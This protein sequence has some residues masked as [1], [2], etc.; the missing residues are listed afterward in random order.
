MAGAGGNGGGGGMAG[1]SGSAPLLGGDA[2]PLPWSEVDSLADVGS[3]P[4]VLANDKGGLHVVAH[5]QH[6]KLLSYS[7]EGWKAGVEYAPSVGSPQ[8]AGA[9]AA[10]LLAW[11]TSVEL[12][13]AAF[14]GQAFGT[15]T[16]LVGPTTID[17]GDLEL[18]ATSTG[19]SAIAFLSDDNSV[20]AA[21]WKNGTWGDFVIIGTAPNDGIARTAQ[22]AMDDM[23][24]AVVIWE[25]QDGVNGFND[26]EAAG[27]LFDGSTWKPAEVIGDDGMETVRLLD[28]A[29][30]R[31]GKGYGAWGETHLYLRP[32]DLATG[33]G[34]M[35]TLDDDPDWLKDQ[36]ALAVN[37]TGDAVVLWSRQKRFDF[38]P[39]VVASFRPAGGSWSTPLLLQDPGYIYE[40]P[41]A[42]LDN[43]GNA[44]LTWVAT[45]PSVYVVTY[46]KASG[47]SRTSR[48]FTATAPDT[49]TNAQVAI[50][51]GNAYVV[52]ATRN[53][54]GKQQLFATHAPL[55]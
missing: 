33:F 29:V 55:P 23:G 36:P 4:D 27:A 46:T 40:Y 28:M 10:P 20:W 17:S 54:T 24:R 15:T 9:A 7:T 47:W 41:A 45:G 1:M 49:V 2:A 25:Q 30:N 19:G 18:L 8:I 21:S 3:Y 51:G 14:N 53:S 48:L 42:C 13:S 35:T 12:Q 22:G 44:A 52:W 31:A 38:V 32:V 6:A 5:S 11:R 50:S 37:D 39:K 43:E 26:R 16:T 34:E